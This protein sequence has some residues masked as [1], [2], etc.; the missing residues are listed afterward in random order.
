VS[1]PPIPAEPRTE[2]VGAATPALPGPAGEALFPY[3]TWGPVKAVAMA[4]TALFA[5][6]LFGLPFLL[7]DG[8]PAGDDLSLFTTVALQI[9]AGLAFIVVPILVA[10]RGAATLG[11][12]MRR[13]GFVSFR[14][15]NAAKWIGIGIA[16]YFIFG[17]LYALVFGAPEQDD[18]AGDFGPIGLQILLI[19]F[20]APLSEEICFRGMLFGGL[21]TR[22]PLW[23]AALGTGA[24]FGLLHYSTGLSAV[25]A[26][27]VL[28]AIFAVV[29]E[30]TGSIWPPIIMHVGNN[31]FALAVL[32]AT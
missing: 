30:K 13:L 32:S 23:A 17:L 26:L 31:A 11:E 25:P 4:V 22:L 12:G 21:R 8:D 28:G 1:Q 6:V 3:A 27:V 2:G 29:Y 7:L 15:G 24:V 20:L 14:P 5:G 16:S 18:I 19:V 10:R 9:C